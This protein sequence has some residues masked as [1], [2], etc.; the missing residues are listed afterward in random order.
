M[1]DN[2]SSI[3]ESAI[4]WFESM[5]YQTAFTPAI[6]P[7]APPHKRHNHIPPEANNP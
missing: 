5:G 4:D 7:D 1:N 6:S 2:V 3:T